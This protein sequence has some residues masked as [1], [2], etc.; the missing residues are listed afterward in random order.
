MIP[1]GEC[2]FSV[3]HRGPLV[4]CIR[5]QAVIRGFKACQD[6]WGEEDEGVE[7]PSSS[8]DACASKSPLLSP[9]SCSFPP[10]SSADISSSG[11][12]SCSGSTGNN[13]FDVDSLADP[14]GDDETDL[15][16]M[17]WS[18]EQVT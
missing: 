7:M 6:A 13:A 1:G 9:G 10:T 11:C 16:L 12:G 15:L 4:A 14:E 18:E 17:G 2:P 8:E 3:S 5:F